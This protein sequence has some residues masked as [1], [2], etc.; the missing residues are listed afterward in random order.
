G[1][2]GPPALGPPRGARDLPVVAAGD[3]VLRRPGLRR[4][5][6]GGQTRTAGALRSA[7]RT[8]H[9]V[10]L[11]FPALLLAPRLAAPGDRLQHGRVAFGRCTGDLGAVQSRWGAARDPLRA[12][13][14]EGGWPAARRTGTGRPG[15]RH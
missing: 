10:Q 7:R 15:R 8:A 2:R 4:G 1:P 9:R 12:S 11:R 13:A 5:V 14:Y 6:G 3:R